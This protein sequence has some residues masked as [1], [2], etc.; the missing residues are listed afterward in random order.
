MKGRQRFGE[1]RTTELS[2]EAMKRTLELTTEQEAQAQE[3]ATRITEAI[4]A[5]VL[6]VARLLVSKDTRHTFGQT[7]FQLRDLIHR[8]GAKALE[9]SL[10]E[11]KTT[12]R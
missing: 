8:A 9:T 12:A 4:A 10:T 3:L 2:E 6:R 1:K 7:E 5:D 11:K